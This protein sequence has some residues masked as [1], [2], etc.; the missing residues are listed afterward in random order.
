MELFAKLI[1]TGLGRW[2]GRCMGFL[3]GSEYDSGLTNNFLFNTLACLIKVCL[4]ISFGRGLC[5]VGISQLICEATWLAGHC[6]VQDFAGSISEQTKVQF[7]SWNQSSQSV[8]LFLYLWRFH[9]WCFLDCSFTLELLCGC[10]L[11][12]VCTNSKR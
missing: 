5:C 8:R 10:F 2:K 11:L 3:Q 6:M 12:S 1:L 9:S 7:Y 4:Q